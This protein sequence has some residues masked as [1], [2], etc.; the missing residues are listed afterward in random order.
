MIPL[1]NRDDI[2]N[3]KKGLRNYVEQRLNE[4]PTEP[5][6]DFP[7]I[8]E[9]EKI[10]ILHNEISSVQFY[11]I[12]LSPASDDHLGMRLNHKPRIESRPEEK[13]H[14][15]VT[16]LDFATP[17]SPYD[18]TYTRIE[19]PDGTFVNEIIESGGSYELVFSVLDCLHNQYPEQFPD[20]SAILA[21]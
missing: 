10:P 7:N 2:I 15:I 20:P 12:G 9:T 3:W 5:D 19:E 13:S 17:Q 4:F 18:G 21:P 8:E 11:R 6:V 16:D 14:N 1:E